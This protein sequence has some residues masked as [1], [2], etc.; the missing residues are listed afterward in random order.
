MSRGDGRAEKITRDRKIDREE[1]GSEDEGQNAFSIIKEETKERNRSRL[2]AN[3]QNSG[4]RKKEKD[5]TNKRYRDLRNNQEFKNKEKQTDKQR[6]QKKRTNPE[7]R[8]S[9]N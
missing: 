3:R 2:R 1:E 4:F 6:L 5:K 8:R 7:L 9:L